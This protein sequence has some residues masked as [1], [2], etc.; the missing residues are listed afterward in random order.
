[1]GGRGLTQPVQGVEVGLHRGVEI[2]S[3][4]LGH[5]LPVLLVTGVDDQDV[6][7]AEGLHHP[8]DHGRVPGLVPDVA[9]QGERLDPGLL[10]QR[11]HLSGVHF[12]RW[13]IGDGDVSAFSCVGDGG[14]PP[15]P[16][17]PARDQGSPSFQSAMAD[18][19][20]LSMIRLRGH[21]A[22]QTR[23]GLG[24]T[25]KGRSRILVTWILHGEPI[26]H[27][28]ILR[29]RAAIMSRASDMPT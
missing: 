23:F 25:R 22:R 17:I 13:Q 15:Y 21:P 26:G 20:V 9:G 16:G 19:A 5:I 28:I 2:V 18:I 4:D 8:G 3:R 7:T 12:L 11:D 14:R 10:D 24:L 6:Q 1:M 29:G 27:E